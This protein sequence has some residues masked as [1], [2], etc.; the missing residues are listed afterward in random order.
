MGYHPGQIIFTFLFVQK[1]S[2]RH[3]VGSG[4]FRS[5]SLP[6]I[7]I[8]P[9]KQS[10]RRRQQADD[11]RNGQSGFKGMHAG[12][13]SLLL[14]SMKED[15]KAI[16]SISRKNRRKHYNIDSCAVLSGRDLFIQYL[17]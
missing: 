14:S 17:G 15:K 10:D 1:I 12:Y 5:R 9:G 6:H 2:L 7:R 8:K 4:G 3:A 11:Q 16:F 13:T